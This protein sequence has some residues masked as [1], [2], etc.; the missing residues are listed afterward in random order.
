MHHKQKHIYVGVDLHKEQ[1]T[2][3][4]ID[5]WHEKLGE[6]TFANKP[7]AFSTFLDEI[8]KYSS[9]DITPVFGLEDVGGYGRSLAVFLIEAMQ[10]VKEVNP[11]HSSNERKS[12][13]M[14]KKDDS[15]DAKCI[16]DVLLNKLDTLPNASP[17]DI[18]WT[19]KQLVGRRNA[20]VK[21][22]MALK[23]QLHNQLSHHYPN[24]K[25][26]FSQID[27][28]VA[29]A[30]WEKY[31]SPYLLEKVTM[32]ELREFLLENSH[33][34][35]STRKAE[36]ILEIVKADGDTKRE[37]QRH[38][39][40]LVQSIIRE[41]RFIKDEIRRIEKEMGK[42]VRSLEY[43]LDTMPGIDLVTASNLI[44]EIGDI[45]RF[46]NPDK[47]AKFAGIAPVKFSSAGKGK[48]Q[49]SQQGRRELNTIFY[50]LAIQQIQVSKGSK[51][52]RNPILYEYYQ[53]KLS[54]GKTKTQALMCIMRRLVNIIYGM[55]RT[56]T[57]YRM[58]YLSK[59]NAS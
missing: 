28:K 9:K 25:Q 26:F 12:Y 47:L 36:E 18:F 1:H 51:K 40:I 24:Y 38:R 15:W 22:H 16:A 49:M 13:P 23:N 6:I 35:C 53:R 50:M 58:E 27:G 57:E 5:C 2:A 52:L 3:V 46:S 54:E 10:D 39:D 11:A 4:I 21:T 45:S 41:L 14:T 59:S 34:A 32:E 19:L 56:K 44:A 20:L 30:F 7:S 33:N 8:R 37:Y 48:E 55:M 31:P 43:K 42:I 17:S 29:L